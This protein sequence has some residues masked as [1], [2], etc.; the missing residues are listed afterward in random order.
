MVSEPGATVTVI[1]CGSG[2]A[3]TE[4]RVN[5]EDASLCDAE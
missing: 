2:V 5:G 1:V 3:P 4:F